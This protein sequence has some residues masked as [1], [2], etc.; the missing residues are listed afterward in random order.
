MRFR[1]NILLCVLFVSLTS[2]SA[3][4]RFGR[5]ALI[6]SD[7][8]VARSSGY[9]RGA[10]TMAV[11]G[12]RQT[13]AAAQSAVR[14]ELDRRSVKV[15]GSV[16]LLLNA[17]FVKA[18]TPQE[19]A[20]LE[21]VPGVARVVWLP[22]VHMKLDKAVQLVNAPA[23]WALFGGVQNAGLG[24]KIA[25]IDSGIDQT[26]PAFQDASLTPPSGYPI[27]A[28]A[29][30]AFTNNKV[31]VARSYVQYD[32][33]GTSPNPA[34]D[35]HPDDLSPRDRVGHGTALAMVA[36]GETNAG[37]AATITG[38]APKAFL[39]NYKIF[40]TPGVN[41]GASYQ[42][43][44]TALEDAVSDGMNVAVLSLGGPALNGPTDTGAVCGAPRGTQCDPEVQAVQNAVLAGVTVVAAAGNEGDTGVVPA[45]QGTIDS[46]G[47]APDAIAVA[48]T[49][50]AHNFVSAIS[51]NGN[52]VPS[53][54]KSIQALF[55]DG[56]LPN[57][58]LTAP[59]VDVST[60]GDQFACT[61]FPAGSLD[62]KIAFVM[63]N[64]SLCT[65]LVK[66]QN[67]Q[68]ARGVGVIIASQLDTDPFDPPGS[69]GGTA[70][71]AV[72]IRASD[73]AAVKSFIDNNPGTA[74][75]MGAGL[76][77]VD[78]NNGNQ[79][80]TF[81]S[82]GP[83]IGNGAI[84]PE[85]AA[86]GTDL[87]LATQNFDPNGALFSPNRYVV[88][89]GT[90]FA[91]PMVGGAAALVRQKNPSYTG[92]Q[93][94]SALINTAS[95]DVT[96]NG[97][98]ASVTAV[99]AGK[100]DVKAA[101]LSNLT[102]EPATLS[103]GTLTASTTLPRSVP[104][105]ITNT[106]ANTLNLTLSVVP[107]NSSG[108]ARVNLDQS[109]L[110]LAPGKAG[111]LNA[112]ISGSLPPFG[113][114]E[115]F[116]RVDG[117]SVTMRIPFLFV[118]GDGVPYNMYILYGDGYTGTVNGGVPDG[119]LAFKV[120]DKYGTPVAG[121]AVSFTN[122]GGGGTV[123][124]SSTTTDQFGIAAASVKLG[125]NSGTNTFVG[126]AGSLKVTFNDP[127]R[128]QPTITP[129]GIV[130]SASFLV[131]QGAAPGSYISIFGTGLADNTGQTSTASLPLAINLVSVSF[132]AGNL[133]LPGRLYY[134]NPNQVNVQVP[135]ELRGQTSVQVK[136]NLEFSK[137][138]VV[139]LLLVTAS[140]AFFEFPDSGTTIAASL[141]ER[142]AVV[143][144]ANPVARGHVVQLFANG[145]GPVSNQPGSGEPAP[146]SPFAQTTATPTVTIGGQNA[147]VQFSGLA[148]GFSGLYQV[149]VVVPANI[150]TG[151]QPLTMSID[152]VAAKTS[153]LPIK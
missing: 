23:A 6:L 84:K 65:F 72:L 91:T 90:S 27:C 131:G 76:V 83:S 51:L 97:S 118:L 10:E 140:P 151:V 3:Q 41:D 80:A 79:V 30:C 85:I 110:S 11:A 67:V 122:T 18:T 34:N 52:G 89:Q 88:S 94:R 77:E 63:R 133:S 58:T 149:N 121:Q 12:K 21:N 20:A 75:S 124:D 126:Q 150:G 53:N 17:I 8:P 38:I 111:A 14:A 113:S 60:I 120:I 36:A 37:P 135:W 93:I 132:D 153:A 137:S 73:G 1:V 103:F 115:G 86:V 45:A 105:V 19:R 139:T 142:S 134:V 78:N 145:L 70:I 68:N 99:G 116:V 130:N 101:V 61:A 102:I 32:A 136:I 108:S 9:R 112:S 82:R 57:G 96:D 92:R 100:L 47:Y 66:V 95:Q 43:I 117:G 138:N 107:T 128:A 54:L 24:T 127:A 5:F 104:L 123:T 98:P 64:R 44:I 71:P 62:G 50:N 144:A 25:I 4:S 146:S 81:S 129:G 69:L 152:G 31:I 16:Q 48:A 39:G 141:D 109:A 42:G 114:Y 147:V 22:P 2:A 13:I 87:Y 55:G 35:S 74:A 119:G 28:P 40:G 106:S 148:P 33:Q 59:V 26:H 29:D 56:P 49:T 143:T 7:E 125:P 15:T 46:P